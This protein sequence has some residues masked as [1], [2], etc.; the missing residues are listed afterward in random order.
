MWTGVWI[1]WMALGS[2]V[3]IGPAPTKTTRTS[4][5]GR[6][7]ASVTPGTCSVCGPTHSGQHDGPHAI[8]ELTGPGERPRRF[9]L[10]HPSMPG[11]FVVLDSGDLICIDHWRRAGVG[12]CLA[13]YRPDG[14]LAWAKTLEELIPRERRRQSPWSNSRPA[15]VR[16]PLGIEHDREEAT[17]ALSLWNSDRLRI[18][19]G[20]GN[21]RYEEVHEFGDDA[22]GWFR[23]ALA[24]VEEGDLERARAC[25]LRAFALDNTLHHGFDPI[26]YAHHRA[27]QDDR[28]IALLVEALDACADSSSVSDVSSKSDPRI[29]LGMTLG[30]AYLRAGR[31]NEAESA[32]RGILLRDPEHEGAEASLVGILY[33]AGRDSEADALVQAAYE[34]ILAGRTPPEGPRHDRRD[35]PEARDGDRREWAVLHAAFLCSQGG[36]AERAAD[37]YR[38]GIA[39]GAWSQRLGGAF[40]LLLEHPLGAH[41]E[42]AEVGQRLLTEQRALLRKADEPKTREHWQRSIHALELRIQ[43]HREASESER[44]PEPPKAGNHLRR[45]SRGSSRR[46][47]SR[48]VIRRCANQRSTVSGSTFQASV[49]SSVRTRIKLSSRNS[50]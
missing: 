6:W 4:A 9:E 40:L 1:A 45:G 8:A 23:K 25:Q 10:L 7:S 29:E 13:R 14:E 3:D 38:R 44:D 37:W 18:E 30:H 47:A 34:R 24:W 19:L 31:T 11:Q 46:D 20:T 49:S 16:H 48:R 27:G 39:D 36:Q 43:R 5:N 2:W 15:W 32:F 41:A 21:A 17:L 26:A 12:R 22:H 33:R 50:H 42:A 28:A 35:E